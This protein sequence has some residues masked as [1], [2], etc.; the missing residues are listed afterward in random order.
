VVLGAQGQRGHVGAG[1]RLGEREAGH[2]LAA[3]QAR[4][5][6]LDHLRGAVGDDRM[7]AQALHGEGG[8]GLGAVPRQALPDEA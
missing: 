8:L 7:S 3:R 2:R 4:D 5:P 6:A 1:A